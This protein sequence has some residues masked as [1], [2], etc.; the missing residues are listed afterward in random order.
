[1]NVNI[2]QFFFT[3]RLTDPQANY[4]EAVVRIDYST[5]GPLPV[6]LINFNAAKT[7]IGALLS[8]QTAQELN[9]K[10]FDVL[11]KTNGS[12]E[13]IGFVDS[14]APN[15]Y[16]TSTLS[17]SF[18]DMSMPSDKIVYYRLAQ[19]DV[20]GKQFLS[21]IRVINNGDSRQP[22]LIYPNPSRGNLQVII[23]ADFTGLSDLRIFSSTG[24]LVQSF[25]NTSDK[26][27][28]VTG[29]KPGIYIVKV[30]NQFDN[31]AYTK[32]LVVQ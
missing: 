5:G 13:K 6:K 26:I 8:W 4:D 15:G 23:P 32:K 20:D 7:S 2:D 21:D 18:N 29:L 22:V 24:S 17:Y 27:I 30:T 14:K 1:L 9:N 28:D 10:G 3:Y 25:T 16:S 19:V 12:F 31:T 11:R